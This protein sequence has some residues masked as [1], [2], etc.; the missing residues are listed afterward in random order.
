[1]TRNT[2]AHL[3]WAHPREQSLTSSL[4][5]AVKE[6][7]VARGCIVDELDLYR[8]GFDPVLH[9]ADEPNWDDPAKVYSDEVETLL[10]RVQ[11]SDIVVVVFPLWWYSLPAILKGYIDRVWNFGRLYDDPSLPKPNAIVW[12]ALA[13]T[14]SEALESGGHIDGLANQLDKGIAG[15]CGIANSRTVVLPDTIDSPD[16]TTYIERVNRVLDESVGIP[17]GQ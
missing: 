10:G 7:L 5:H 14:T 16:L 1:M 13:G 15:Y 2:R 8:Y 3:V 12:V 6:S 4:V 11:N 9:E 17:R